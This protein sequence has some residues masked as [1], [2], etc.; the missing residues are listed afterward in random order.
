MKKTSKSPNIIMKYVHHTIRIFTGVFLLAVFGSKFGFLFP[1]PEILTQPASD[2]AVRQ[3]SFITA[4]MP[5]GKATTSQRCPMSQQNHS[6]QP[7]WRDI[8][9][10]VLSKTK[11]DYRT[12]IRPR[13]TSGK[14]R[15]GSWIERLGQRVKGSSD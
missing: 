10:T 14:T 8:A 3:N 6:A 13:M 1:F 9:Q 11:D 4:L 15:L 2:L 5:L 12:T 7:S